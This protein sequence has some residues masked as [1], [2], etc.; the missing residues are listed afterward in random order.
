MNK[1]ASFLN[2]YSQMTQTVSKNERYALEIAL[3][4]AG[5]L[6][7][8]SYPK[9]NAPPE[10]DYENAVFTKY[11]NPILDS[12]NISTPISININIKSDLSVILS[13]SGS[14]QIQPQL[15]KTIGNAMTKALLNA[16]QRGEIES[17][18]HDISWP[19]II[20]YG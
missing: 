11:I 2:I 17:P 15:Q 12:A 1:L 19:W 6:G 10:L 5:L 20:N 13:V 18:D 3:Y 8:K 7:L 9:S 14:P 4:K 16:K